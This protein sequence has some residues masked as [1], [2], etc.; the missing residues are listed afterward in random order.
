MSRGLLPDSPNT[1]LVVRLGELVTSVISDPTFD[2]CWLLACTFDMAMDLPPDKA[3]QWLS[4][5]VTARI[6]DLE[7]NQAQLARE[8]SA[9]Y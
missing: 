5:F 2:G 8:R 1:S 7:A 6:D 9:I 3:A 4:R